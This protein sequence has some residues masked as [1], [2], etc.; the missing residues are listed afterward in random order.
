MLAL[1]AANIGEVKAGAASRA[2]LFSLVLAGALFWLLRVILR[3]T[4][5]SA[6]LTT[7]LL[8]LFFTY[9]HAYM[10]L[11]AKRPELDHSL[12]LLGVWALLALLAGFWA[13]RRPPAA[14]RLN[15]IAFGLVAVSLIQIGFGA[16]DGGG[17]SLGAEHAPIQTDLV[18]P[19]DPPDIYYFILDSYARQDLLETA[20][21]FDI[22]A[23][24]AALES[25]G[26]YIA[27]CSQ[28]NYT[29]TEISLGSSLNMLYLQDLDDAFTPESTRRGVLWDAL[30]HGAVRYNLE[31]LGYKTVAF[32]T[33]YAWNE[34]TDADLYLSPPAFS[35]GLS[36]FEALLIQTTLARHLTDVGWLDPDEIVG[37]NYRDRFNLIFDSLDNLAH[38]PGPI[39]AHI[40]VMSP[41]PPFV[42]DA[43]GKPTHP[44]DFWNEKRLYPA[45]LYQEGYVNQAAYLNKKMLEGIDMLLSESETPPVIIIQGDHGPWLQPREQHMWILNAYHLPGHNDVLYPSISPVNTFRLVFNAYFGGKYDI[46]EDVSYYS[47]VP[48]LYEFSVIRNRCAQGSGR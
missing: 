40:H 33:G 11:A 48:H 46:L 1:L 26:F 8:A 10:L 30:K 24:I 7:L 22:G 4:Q 6:F 34:L 28:S 32:A 15:L 42:F 47:P 9:G 13:I 29:R 43:E 25:R 12:L 19:A 38:V 23:F 20:Y 2:L 16:R 41:H 5:S 44:A 3:D 37:Q 14:A 27:D 17:H 21:G 35:S 45:R 36:E 18:L 39:F 31:S